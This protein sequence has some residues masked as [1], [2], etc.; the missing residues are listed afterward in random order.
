[1]ETLTLSATSL[2]DSNL[3]LTE[4]LFP[5][6]G[7]QSIVQPSGTLGKVSPSG[8]HVTLSPSLPLLGWQM[9]LA[10]R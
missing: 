9:L 6:P 8:S 4:P 1:M 10:Y 7:T 5:Y 2:P 3:R